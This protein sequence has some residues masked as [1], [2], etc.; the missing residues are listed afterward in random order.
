MLKLASDKDLD[1]IISFCD[2]DLLGTRIGCYC[3][4]YGFERD[5]LSVWIDDSNGKIS[6]VIAKFYDSITLVSNSDSVNEIRD[7][8]DMTGYKSLE[9][10]LETSEKAGLKGEDVKKSYL[11]SAE[12][13]NMGAEELTEEYYKELYT[14]VSDNIPDSFLNT[15]EA[16]LSF[17]SDF[18]FRKRRGFARSKGIITDN[19]L[20]S[21]VITSAETPHNALISA[22]AS[23]KNARGKGL[24]KKTVLT[25]VSELCS[26]NK[27]V[28]V[29]ALNESAEGFYEHL[30]FKFYR[31][32]VNIKG[33]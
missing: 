27:R 33:K 22:V 12:A 15:K 29:I 14:L 16:Y 13:E 28:F 9:M 31:N 1:A 8:I 3:L 7:F 25:M 17:L 6:T 5:F 4:A 19:R 21:S 23:D 11:F 10:Y 26:E 30:G 32:I 24:G 20:S 2:G 18:T